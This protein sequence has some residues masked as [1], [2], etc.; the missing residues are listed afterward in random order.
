MLADNDACAVTID[1]LLKGIVGIVGVLCSDAVRE[2]LFF[3]PSTVVV[4]ETYAVIVR[5]SDVGET[6][7]WTSI[8]FRIG[9]KLNHGIGSL[10]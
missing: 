7:V 9:K 5:R 3:K 10:P 8:S 6:I 4:N 2:P 1:D